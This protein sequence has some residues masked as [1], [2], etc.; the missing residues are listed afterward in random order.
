MS[1]KI[2]PLWGSLA[3]ACCGEEV[4][5]RGAS[6]PRGLVEEVMDLVQ[7]ADILTEAP[8]K[9]KKARRN[10]KKKKAKSGKFY[11]F[12]RKSLLGPGP[13]GKTLGKAGK[14]KCRCPGPSTSTHIS[15]CICKGKVVSPTT[16][17]ARTVTKRVRIKRKYKLWYNR[18]FKAHYKGPTGEKAKKRAGKKLVKKK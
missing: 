16:G 5:D 7:A 12:K 14:W 17:K 8:K 4:E 3:T 2:H 18:L 11:P 13:L 10:V 1:D 15:Q 6:S 9:S